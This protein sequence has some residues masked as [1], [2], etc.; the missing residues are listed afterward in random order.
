MNAN[1]IEADTVYDGEYN[2][3]QIN[4]FL[5]LKTLNLLDF[6]STEDLRK[7]KSQYDLVDISSIWTRATMEAEINNQKLVA[8]GKFYAASCLNLTCN[9]D[10]SAMILESTAIDIAID[11]RKL[12]NTSISFK[13]ILLPQILNKNK[14]NGDQWAGLNATG[15]RLVNLNRCFVN[16]PRVQDFAIGLHE[17]ATN[18]RGNNYNIITLGQLNNNKINHY[19]SADNL[20]V[21]GTASWVNQN[22]HEGGSYSHFSTEGN[23]IK[24]C[25]HLKIEANLLASN[26]NT[27]NDPSFENSACDFHVVN[28]GRYNFIMN[29]RWEVHSPYKPKVK[30]FCNDSLSTA[31]NHGTR[32]EITGGYE[33]DFIA[34]E[35]Q[36]NSSE[37]INTTHSQNNSLNNLISGRGGHRFRNKSSSNEAIFTFFASNTQIELAD[38]N[39]Y[40]LQFSANEIKGKRSTDTNN[41]IKIDFQNAS[42]GF[43]DG[44]TTDYS[45]LSGTQTS[46]RSSKSFIPLTNSQLDL[47]SLNFRWKNL[48]CSAGLGVFGKTPPTQK[49]SIVGKKTPTTLD[50]CRSLINDLVTALESFGF[51]SDDRE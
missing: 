33:L 3:N 41:R 2:Q 6:F 17:W 43:G 29:A 36:G 35:F 26:G 38:Q 45:T 13:N 40:Q 31:K 14:K 9:A 46:I 30:Y 21:N 39:T 44:I 16:V 11:V 28:G 25:H 34:Y 5:N 12:D 48:Y 22:K 47:G 27:F 32:N 50:E 42:I 20:I 49:I 23:N 7:Y 8:F 19:L 1:R 51:I 37:F 18:G 4:T 24:D 10:L 15:V